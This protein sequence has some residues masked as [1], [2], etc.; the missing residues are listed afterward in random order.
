MIPLQEQDRL[1]QRFAERLT[2]GVKIEHFTQR[3]LSIVIAGREECRFCSETRQTLEELRAL[4]PKVSLRVHELSESGTLAASLGVERVPATI[5]RGQLN[6]L[7][8]FD[9]F[10]GAGLFPP[11]V[12]ALIN[13]SR[14]STDLDGR[15]KR[16]LGRVR[17]RLDVRVFVSPSG[18]YCPPM[19]AMAYAFGLENQ[20]LRVSVVEIDEFPRL[21]ESMQIRAV[22][23]TVIGERA[24]FVG[25]VP[26]D[27]FIGQ[28]AL[29]AEGHTLPAGPSLLGAP[30][31]PSTAV[32]AAPEPRTSPGGLILPGRG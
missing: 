31:G 11:F 16:S 13:T 25:A 26:P 15:F 30:A 21:T 7:L 18:P 17:G 24:R 8:R 5:L 6:R 23:T 19:T 20:R 1:R 10:P 3:S 28:L 27:V 22:P 4:S 29:A 32:G 9:G 14:G 12:D 2:G